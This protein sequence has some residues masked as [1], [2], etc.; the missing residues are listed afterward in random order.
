M[1]DKCATAG[2]LEK[3]SQ[4][5]VSNLLSQINRL[6]IVCGCSWSGQG[7]EEKLIFVA[8]T[9]CLNTYQK[10][11]PEKEEDMVVPD[12][13]NFLKRWKAPCLR[14]AHVTETMPIYCF[15]L[16]LLLFSMGPLNYHVIGLPEGT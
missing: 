2:S 3:T 11:L 15:F 13:Y 10:W 12:S 16:F 7:A 8:H 5:F 14:S 6:E 1:I 9:G 4:I